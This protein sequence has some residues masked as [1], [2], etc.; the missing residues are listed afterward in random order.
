[1]SGSAYDDFLAESAASSV[2]VVPQNAQ[3]SN[4][5]LIVPQMTFKAPPKK[6]KR[7]ASSTPKKLKGQDKL[8]KCVACDANNDAEYVHPELNVPIC[9]RCNK[10]HRDAQYDVDL[11][12]GNQWECRL[13]GIGDGNIM[14]MCDKCPKSFCERC[15][16]NVIGRVEAN[17]V[18]KY[19]KNR[20]WLCFCCDPTLPAFEKLTV[21]PEFTFFNIESVYTSVRPPPGTVESLTPVPQ[22]LVNSLSEGERALC[23]LFCA[24]A[25]YPQISL[26]RIADAF[27]T[28][29]GKS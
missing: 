19:G 24:Q 26:L 20:L 25:G 16:F 18:R 12:T 8:V 7:A 15:T 11:E 22:A 6:R 2:P 5:A 4:A 10:S 23:R 21:S 14:F 3:S 29:V 27:L 1:M 9:G 13:C 28:A 17:K